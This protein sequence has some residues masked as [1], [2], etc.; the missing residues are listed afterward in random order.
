MPQMVLARTIIA[1]FNKPPKNLKNPRNGHKP[2]Q[3]RQL[4]A[5]WWTTGRACESTDEKLGRWGCWIVG[6]VRGDSP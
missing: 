6:G 1:P 2:L 5:N 3:D 4:V